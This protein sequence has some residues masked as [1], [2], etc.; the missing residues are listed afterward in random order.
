MWDA[1]VEVRPISGDMFL[2]AL[3]LENYF[4]NSEQEN[5]NDHFKEEQTPELFEGRARDMECPLQAS[6]ESWTKLLHPE[7]KAAIQAHRGEWST[8]G[9]CLR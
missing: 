7:P 3:E 8:T 9:V 5:F 4:E 1:V 6:R 2:L